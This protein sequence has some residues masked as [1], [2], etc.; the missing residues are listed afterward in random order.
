MAFLSEAKK[1]G[2]KTALKTDNAHFYILK[3][4]IFW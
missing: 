4:G 3:S 2:F 1:S